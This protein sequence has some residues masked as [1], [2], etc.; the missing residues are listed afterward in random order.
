LSKLSED[1]KIGLRQRYGL[2]LREIFW[3]LRFAPPLKVG[4][5]PHDKALTLADLAGGKR[6]IAHGSHAQSDID[7]FLNQ[8]DTAIVHDDLDFQCR[9]LFE[10]FGKDRNDMQPTKGDSDADTEAAG[11]G[12]AGAAGLSF[13]G[14]CGWP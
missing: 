8:I 10:K 12:C 4:R 6:G 11:Q 13:A 5:R 2:M 7:A 1:A 14:R 9:M 3:F